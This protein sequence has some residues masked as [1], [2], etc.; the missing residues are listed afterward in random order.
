MSRGLKYLK[1]IVNCN[2][3]KVFINQIQ[4]NMKLKNVLIKKIICLLFIS[5]LAF[6][7]CDIVEE[8]Y[9]KDFVQQEPDT[10]KP[11]ILLEEYTGFKCNNCPAGHSI[12]KQL[13]NLY[14]DRF[15]VVAI[16][17]GNWAKPENSGDKYRYDFRTQVG[18]D[19]SE[20]YGVIDAP[21]GIIN[22]TRYNGEMILNTGSWDNAAN[23]FWENN[24]TAEVKIELSASYNP[25]TRQIEANVKLNYLSPQTHKNKVSVWI[26]ED[27]IINWQLDKN[28]TPPDVPDYVHNNVLRESFNGTWGD[29]VSATAIPKD[30]IFDKKYSYS[31]PSDSDWKLE[32]LKVIAFVYDDANGIKQVERVKIQQ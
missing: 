32:N 28:S 27:S 15:F 10:T 6:T 9:R 17:Y 22:R 30:F 11:K 13:A 12:A 1:I 21:R 8:P 4:K 5:S 20:F 26:L 29:E 18:K 16:H 2:Q 24:K 7:S 14:P 23:D 19:L 3:S 25:A 31:L